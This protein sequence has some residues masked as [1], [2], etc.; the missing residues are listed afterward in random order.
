MKVY[1]ALLPLLAAMTMIAGCESRNSAEVMVGQAQDAVDKVRP[2]AAAANTT[3]ELKPVEATLAQMKQSFDQGEYKAVKTDASQFNAQ[4]KTLVDAMTAKQVENDAII[5]EW[6]TLNTEVPKS[7][8]AVQARVDS[9]K[10]NAL[11]KEVTKDELETAKKDLETAKATWDEATK[12]ANAGHP[13]EA[14][15]KARIVQAKMEE[16]KSS[17]GMTEQVASNTPPSAN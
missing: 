17:L 10:P 14:R 1:Q 15:D 11:P 13:A 16:L 4:Y 3:E 5:Q 7:V 2:Q 12:A 6:G 9:L 8:E